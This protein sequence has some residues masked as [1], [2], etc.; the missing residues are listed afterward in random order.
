MQSQNHIGLLEGA[1]NNISRLEGN[2]RNLLA[3]ATSQLRVSSLSSDHSLAQ[4][5]HN[6]TT[7]A[8]SG[9]HSQMPTSSS[10]TQLSLAARP[11]VSSSSWMRSLWPAN[12]CRNAEQYRIGRKAFY[13]LA[14][15][16]QQRSDALWQC[17]KCSRHFSKVS[18]P[19][20]NTVGYTLWIGAKG[21]FKAHGKGGWYCIWQRVDPSCYER[22]FEDEWELMK[23]MR[24]HHTTV[25]ANP[26][27]F[28][29]EKPA[30]ICGDEFGFGAIIRGRELQ[31]ENFVG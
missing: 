31:N 24:R 3:P 8:L 1:Q 26:A 7:Q 25:D 2:L 9:L 29:M 19:I 13:E 5:S 4:L 6:L 16:V 28:K 22:P 14:T 21:L 15:E 11:V 10:P 27:N 12:L 20:E 23:H 17:M 30:D 18:A